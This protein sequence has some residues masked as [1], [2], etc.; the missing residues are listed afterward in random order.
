MR[1]KYLVLLVGETN[2]GINVWDP[3]NAETPIGFSDWGELL[4][5]YAADGWE[6]LEA[7]PLTWQLEKVAARLNES[8]V[9]LRRAAD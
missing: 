9:I 2:H 8:R 5:K 1:Y 3:E 7:H 6:F 4:N